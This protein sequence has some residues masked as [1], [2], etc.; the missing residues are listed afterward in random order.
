MRKLPVYGLAL[1][2]GMAVLGPVGGLTNPIPVGPP[3][4]LDVSGTANTAGFLLFFAH[5]ASIDANA[6]EAAAAGNPE[7]SQWRSFEQ[8]M[9]G[10]TD[11]EGAILKQVAY[12]CNQ[13]LND[14]D[15]AIAAGDEPAAGKMEIGSSAVGQLNSLLG[16]EAFQKVAGRVQALFGNLADLMASGPPDR[17]PPVGLDG[18]GLGPPVAANVSL[19]YTDV[20]ST[21]SKYGEHVFYAECYTWPQDELSFNDYT[22]KTSCQMYGF[23]AP[24]DIACD[25]VIKGFC[26]TMFTIVPGKSFFAR[27][28]HALRMHS[29]LCSGDEGDYDCLDDPLHYGSPPGTPLPDFPDGNRIYAPGGPEVFWPTTFPNDAWLIA[30]THSTPTTFLNVS[31]RQVTLYPN[32]V[33][34]FTSNIP[35]KWYIFGPGAGPGTIDDSGLFTAPATITSAQTTIVT[36]CDGNPLYEPTL[37]DCL[38]VTVNLQPLKV[39]LS[40]ATAEILPDLFTTFLT[41]ITPSVPGLH[42]DWSLSTRG[43][44]PTGKLS[45]SDSGAIYT[46]PKNDDMTVSE[47]ITIKA[48]VKPTATSEP[49][50]GT[51]LVT[52]PSFQ[53]YVV[54]DKKTLFRG[55]SEPFTAFVNSTATVPQKITWNA[56]GT[57]G[58]GTFSVISDDT[59]QAVYRAPDFRSGVDVK[60]CLQASASTCSV[61]RYPFHLQI[62]DPV[63]LSLVTG[64][65]NAGETAHFIISGAG[66]GT[67][68]AVQFTSL[69]AAVLSSSDSTIDGLVVI[70]VALG[71]TTTRASVKVS[72]PNGDFFTVNWPTPI[73]LARASVQVVPATVQ[74]HGGETQ[75]F[76]PICLTA[77]AAA[78]TSPDTVSWQAS[79]GTVNATGK[80]TAPASIAANTAATVTACWSGG[81]CAVAQVTLLPAAGVTVSVTPKTATVQAGHTQPFGAQVT[82][83]T[84]T[85]VTWSLQ[86]QT[87]E[88]GTIASTGL[89]SAPAALG[90]V[91]VVTVIATSQADTTRQ[92]TATVTLTAAPQP[93]TLAS[94]PSP[95][96][97]NYGTTLTWTAHASGGN[98]ATTQY[99][100]FRRRAGTVPWTPD[101]TAPA[102]QTGNVFS[103]TPGAGD[104]GTWETYIWVRD[105]NTPATMNTYGYAAGCNPGPVQIT[106]P[107]VPLTL[108]GTGSPAAA[109]Y[110]T[111]LTWTATAYGGNPATTQY[112]L[113]RRLAGSASWT[114]DVTAPAWQTGNVLV[115]TTGAGD[116][117]TWETYIWVRDGNTPAT[118]NTYGYAAGYNPGPVQ[119]T[120]PYVPL[121][122]T[123]TGSPPAANYGTT[124][125][126]T[127]TAYGGNPATTQYALFRRL[128][129]SASWTP[130]VTA[131]A[132]QTGNVLVWTPGSGD[133]G[134]WETYIWVRDGNTPFN[135]N[136]Y[137]YA[138]GYNPGLV[139]ITAPYTPITL[140]GTFSPASASYGTTLTWTANASGGDPATIQYAFFRRRAGTVPWIPDVTAPAWQ[141][142]NVLVWTPGSGDVG[143]WETY[144]WVRDGNT[145]FN[146]NT[147][148]YAA[149]YNSLPVQIT[150]VSQLYPA[151]G[152]VDGYNSQHIWGWACDPD[153]PT[154]SNRVDIGVPNG[155]GL[156]SAGADL[157]S[158]AGIGNACLGGTAHYFDFYPS[159]GIP[160][161]THFNVWSIDLPYATPGNDNRKVGGTGA[162]GDG[163]EFVIP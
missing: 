100:F 90:S 142:G 136:T 66:F 4:P 115:W 132:W 157:A 54:A 134:T 12:A 52:V 43:S 68:P 78:C 137:G 129:G 59:L 144:I 128:A 156:G 93:P 97:A 27:G 118:M 119:I 32:G 153:Y 112:A 31:P 127:A 34:R 94:T 37:V 88:A 121:T 131:P 6:D 146:M 91:T 102:W 107:Y 113:F 162:I 20:Y 46:A 109:N 114:P 3:P 19:P 130:E 161:G 77:S 81:V 85:G 154:Q 62:V 53:L 55:E 67:Q 64:T 7:A 150:G 106:A 122:L 116:V 36:A 139:Q 79:L 47:Q 74:L 61:P 141:T 35:T 163:T 147:Y 18:D 9:A 96:A 126:W 152:W 24:V 135:M 23:A 21:V 155:P 25:K 84:N 15:A 124:L 145:P 13:A 45:T 108:T 125:T 158:G 138:A 29:T 33:Q 28:I 48:C 76:S 98:P 89:Y 117:G 1:A 123:G 86:P 57:N 60:V 105:G 104:V 30:A 41:T 8:R 133:V 42:V 39:E 82:G 50:C 75:Q 148:G 16:D 40:P 58:N 2:I 160:S 159:G 80:Y 49:V 110:G 99:A 83:S 143:T 95:A 101:V 73:P 63:T 5:L 11:A 22:G 10:L 51:A 14:H 111:T 72:Y 65:F 38:D 103:W 44:D 71:G 140:T 87:A 149:G 17:L 56:L 151:K 70:P 120:A 69:Q 92:D 26:E